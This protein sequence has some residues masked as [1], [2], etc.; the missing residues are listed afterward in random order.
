VGFG[1]SADVEVD[2][3][4]EEGLQYV[5]GSDAGI[6][7]DRESELTRDGEAEPVRAAAGAADLELWP[8]P[9]QRPVGE[10]RQR[11][12]ALHLLIDGNAGDEVV[13]AGLRAW[14]SSRGAA[15]AASQT[16]HRG[17]Q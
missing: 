15:A 9:G 4:V 12:Q 6:G 17:H 14:G 3:L 10:D 11:P 5:S 7:G 1:G 8:S 2:Q 13:G 16:W